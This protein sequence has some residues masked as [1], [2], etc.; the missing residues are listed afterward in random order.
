MRQYKKF[1][2][3]TPSVVT[4][5]L[6]EFLKGNERAAFFNSNDLNKKYASYDFLCASGTVK[7]FTCPACDI[8]PA[9]KRFFYEVQDWLFGFF[10]YDLKNELENLISAHDDNIR[11]PL[12]HFFQP[13][14]VFLKKGD[15]LEIGYIPELYTEQQINSIFNTI[16]NT[17]LSKKK[18]SE[19][20]V[21]EKVSAKVEMEAYLEKIKT[22]KN[23]IQLGNIYEMNFCVE[24][25]T[26][27]N[28]AAEAVD[29]YKL[30]NTISPAPFSCL[31]KLGDKSLICSSPERFLKK[32]GNHLVSQ[33]IKGTIKRGK[34]DEEDVRLKQELANNEKEKSENV[35]IVDLVRNDLSYYAEK[36]SVNVEELC[37]I[38]SYAQVHQMISTIACT[39]KKEAC[40]IDAIMKCFPPGSMTGAPKISAMQIIEDMEN[41]KRGLYAGAVGYFTPERDFDFNVVIRSIIINNTEKYASLMAGGAITAGSE[42]EKE[43]EECLLKAY[44]MNKTLN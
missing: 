25:F 17:G 15:I 1:K 43:Y 8:I 40:V 35:M 9:F 18:N 31:Y 14:L 5:S 42:A 28:K 3:E 21:F 26:R 10:S 11:M 12:I 33:P 44:A 34:T 37:G 32:E 22:I 30:L 4:D 36:G 2:L 23:H 16:N 27:F 13:Q 20:P 6:L 7:E 24:F 29:M 19:V 38:Y 39:L 41:T